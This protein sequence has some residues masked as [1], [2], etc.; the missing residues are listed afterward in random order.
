[1][2][3]TIGADPVEIKLADDV[4]TFRVR[5][6]QRGRM[7]ILDLSGRDDMGPYEKSYVACEAALVGWDGVVGKEGKPI[8][9]GVNM[10]A[11]LRALDP[12]DLFRLA[13]E[14]LRGSELTETDRKN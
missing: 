10:D 2:P 1:M 8:R 12:D 11:N 6:T 3:P 5:L 14:I 4:R 9:F 7:R 13:A